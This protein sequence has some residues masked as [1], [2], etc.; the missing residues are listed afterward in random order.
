MGLFCDET[1]SLL[2]TRSWQSPSVITGTKC[3]VR[4]VQVKIAPIPRCLI[5]HLPSHRSPI[6]SYQDRVV[7]LERVPSQDLLRICQSLPSTASRIDAALSQPSW[8]G[9]RGNVSVASNA[10]IMKQEQTTSLRPTQPLIHVGPVSNPAA[11][12]FQACY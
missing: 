5:E 4:N 9:T 3:C 8:Y 7:A 1:P 2:S 12:G 11:Y 6:C 10:T